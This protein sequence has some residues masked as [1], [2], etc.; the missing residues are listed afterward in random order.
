MFFRGLLLWVCERF[1]K[2]WE[3][4]GWFWIIIV[5]SKVDIIWCVYCWIYE[6]VNCEFVELF[7]YV[8]G[9]G[10]DIGI[11]WCLSIES[12]FSYWGGCCLIFISMLR[13][14]LGWFFERL[15]YGMIFY[16]GEFLWDELYVIKVIIYEFNLCCIW[17]ENLFWCWF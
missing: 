1:L 2:W 10:F 7:L 4:C 3:V 17:F 9:M 8:E 13:F 16:G 6:D 15:C 12:C 5:I 14:F 11:F